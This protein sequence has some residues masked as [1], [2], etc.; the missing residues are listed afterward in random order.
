MSITPKGE[1]WSLV[2]RDVEIPR[3]PTPLLFFSTP[4]SSSCRLSKRPAGPSLAP[5]LLPISTPFCFLLS[6]NLSNS[7]K[8]GP[9]EPRIS[10][11]VFFKSWMTQEM[12]QVERLPSP[13]YLPEE[14]S[15]AHT[16]GPSQPPNPTPRT[17]SQPPHPKNDTGLTQ[18][19]AATSVGLQLLSEQLSRGG[20]EEAGPPRITPT[21]ARS[22]R[23]ARVG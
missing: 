9:R 1:N 20:K 12:F 17:A 21:A 16:P 6:S 14:T 2:S 15:E 11:P 5:T 3:G 23:S 10:V 22:L 4:V 19:S 18:T 13:R 8:L 7:T